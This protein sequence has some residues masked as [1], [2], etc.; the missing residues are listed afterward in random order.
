MADLERCLREADA[1]GCPQKLVVTDGVFSMDGTHRQP[2][3]H[4]RAGREASRAGDDRTSATRW[5]SSAAP[6]AARPSCTACADAWTSSR[7]RWARRS[8]ARSADSPPRA[9]RSSSCCA[10]V[11]GPYL[12]SNAL[13]PAVVGAGIAVLDLLAGTTELRDRLEANTQRFRER[14]DGGRLR[15]S[16]RACIRS[17]PIMLYDERLAHEMAA[18]LL[19]RGIYVVGFSYPGRGEGP[20]AHPRAAVSAAHTPSMSIAPS[21][22]SRE[23]RRAQVCWQGPRRAEHAAC[24]STRL[25]PAARALDPLRSAPLRRSHL[26]PRS[27]SV[28]PS[29]TLRRTPFYE[30]HRAGRRRS[31]WTSPASRCRC[32]TRVTCASTSRCATPWDCSTSPT[33]ASSTCAGPGAMEWLES[34]RHERRRRHSRWAR[35]STRPCAARMPASWTTCWSIATPTTSWWW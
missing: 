9:G 14:H 22:R 3:G 25:D 32:A 33:W 1:K 16:S 13:P 11:R 6:A 30:F 20:G 34:R 28:Q 31:W 23:D 8:A 18:R 21:P 5:D 29:P 17:C 12:F 7:A 26:I 24:R 19:E 27:S 4:R 10:S 35:R 15:R 2:E